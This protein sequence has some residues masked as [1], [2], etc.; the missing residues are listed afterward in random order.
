MK[1]VQCVRVALVIGAVASASA[2]H[3]HP[4]FSPESISDF[5]AAFATVKPVRLSMGRTWALDARHTDRTRYHAY[6]FVIPDTVLI[7]VAESVDVDPFGHLRI[8][9][10]AGGTLRGRPNKT[11]QE[12]SHILVPIS[13]R[14]PM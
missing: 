2:V 12:Y 14:P 7:G 6:R 9:P 11:H 13:V 5:A 1:V 8:T 3:A 4:A 10:E